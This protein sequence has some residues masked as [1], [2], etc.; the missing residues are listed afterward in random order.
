MGIEFELKFTAAPE[1]QLAIRQAMA[2]Y[3][4][5]T[6]QMETTY[7]DTPKGELSQR[8]YTLR[9]RF[10]NGVSVCTV[11][12]PAGALGRGE[13]EVECDTI[14][15]AIEPLCLLGAPKNLLLLTMNGVVPICGARFTRQC[16]TLA[17]DGCT[18]ELALDSGVLTGGSREIPLCEVEV[19]LKDGDRDAAIRFAEGLANAYSLT[20]QHK[21]KFRRALDL[22][23]GE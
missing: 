16:C 18:V 7:Y 23:K 17:L 9:R 6:I 22:Y 11:K 1:D 8:H 21:S 20:P 19:E 12:T 2:E 4:F 13:W 5:Q 15:N 14:E 3:A 10:E